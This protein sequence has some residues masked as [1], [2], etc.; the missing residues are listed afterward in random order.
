MGYIITFFN[1][2]EQLGSQLALYT[3]TLLQSMV[4]FPQIPE[5]KIHT[6]D[7]IPE[8]TRIALI[9][10]AHACR[11]WIIRCQLKALALS[12]KIPELNDSKLKEAYTHITNT[13]IPSKKAVEEYAFLINNC[14]VKGTL[15]E[16]LKNIEDYSKLLLHE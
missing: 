3:S 15:N 14:F 13:Y 7:S 9:E 12:D 10:Q 5:E 8:S 2:I 6:Y 11:H 1:D 16:L 4:D